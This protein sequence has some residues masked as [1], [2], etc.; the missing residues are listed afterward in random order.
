MQEY[1]DYD[2]LSKEEA[3][4]QGYDTDDDK[5]FEGYSIINPGQ[6]DEDNDLSYE[7]EK[8]RD[9]EDRGDDEDWENDEDR[10]GIENRNDHDDLYNEEDEEPR[11]SDSGEE[12]DKDYWVF[13]GRVF[14]D[15]R[16][17][18]QAIYKKEVYGYPQ[19]DGEEQ[20]ALA[21]VIRRGMLCECSLLWGDPKSVPRGVP[22]DFP[23]DHPYRL[24]A[25]PSDML[26][27]LHQ[28]EE[29]EAWVKGLSKEEKKKEITKGLAAQK[30]MIC[31]NLALVM[32]V[33]GKEHNQLEYMDRVEVG[34]IGLIKAVQYFNPYKGYQF[35]TF[36][37][38]LIQNEI[39]DE[40]KK[41]RRQRGGSKVWENYVPT[42][43][44]ID[45]VIER[46]GGKYWMKEITYDTKMAEEE[47]RK[48]VSIL[49]Q[50]KVYLE[51][52][53]N[54]RRFGC[55][56]KY[57]E[58]LET[59]ESITED[60]IKSGK[61][62]KRI[63]MPGDAGTENPDSNY[64][65]INP[66]FD[67]IKGDGKPP[68]AK[69]L[70]FEDYVRTFFGMIVELQ[71]ITPEKLALFV[72]RN[73]KDIR[74][75]A[76]A[77]RRIV[78]GEWA[79][80]E[81][82]A[83]GDLEKLIGSGSIWP[84]RPLIKQIMKWA[85]IDSESQEK[86]ALCAGEK[87]DQELQKKKALRPEEKKALCPQEKDDQDA[88]ELSD[89]IN[90]D[91]PTESIAMILL[92]EYVNLR[93]EDIWMD[94]RMSLDYYERLCKIIELVGEERL[95]ERDGIILEELAEKKKYTAIQREQH[96]SPNTVR[97]SKDEII[98]SLH[99]QIVENT[100][101]K[102]CEVVMNRLVQKYQVR[103]IRDWENSVINR[104]YNDHFI[105]KRRFA[106]RSRGAADTNRPVLETY[107][108]I[109]ATSAHLVQ[110]TVEV[111]EKVDEIYE[112]LVPAID[113]A[114]HA[115]QV[116]SE[117][118]RP[119]IDTA[120]RRFREQSEALAPT[121]EAIAQFFRSHS[122]AEADE[123]EDNQTDEVVTMPQLV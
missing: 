110:G 76:T 89:Y 29:E 11:Y 53:A 32:S 52:I 71:T 86:K 39:R 6:E 34:S 63:K 70:S 117:A 25:K 16:Q 118:V 95:D 20:I 80:T 123:R 10:D 101:W 40:A 4:Y 21:R 49:L 122:F 59:A 44:V 65:G 74:D 120:V 17:Y 46:M 79:Y 15:L 107:N 31:S 51:S 24:V 94:A 64:C 109:I 9:K 111:G 50:R 96:V 12:K 67:I 98:R 119:G 99:D 121:V 14:K 62:I 5:T 48:L 108:R 106:L 36:A 58:V 60:D 104:M 47:I 61:V 28:T 22:E 69:E 112:G 19:L 23:K 13:D 91:F 2:Y 7:E 114:A 75:K 103:V 90:I 83:I 1:T 85:N 3:E 78:D 35:S 30:K 42:E 102:Y 33:A 82:E 8:E 113:A 38:Y 77:L 57:E 87:D 81:A 73:I 55:S 72:F 92:G 66:R 105:E 45:A 68:K 37:T 56:T 116:S 84:E 93:Q 88:D 54:D 27:R 26:K 43:A 18:L 115:F 97:K 41:Q 100:N